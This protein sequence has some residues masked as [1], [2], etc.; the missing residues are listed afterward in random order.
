MGWFR[1]KQKE[2]AEIF[3]ED[4]KEI[5]QTKMKDVSLNRYS[6]IL[7]LLPLVVGIAEIVISTDTGSAQGDLT[8]SKAIVNYG[9]INIYNK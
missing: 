6:A 9:T 7:K 5:L 2:V 8:G 1:K 3:V 4:T